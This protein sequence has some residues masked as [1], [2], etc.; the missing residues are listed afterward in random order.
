LPSEDHPVAYL[1][2]GTA[3]QPPTA[4]PEQLQRM[5]TGSKIERRSTN[6]ER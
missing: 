6:D 5:V 4:D 3:C 1:C 2:T